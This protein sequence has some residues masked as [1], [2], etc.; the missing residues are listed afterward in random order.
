MIITQLI[1]KVIGAHV[2]ITIFFQLTISILYIIL[3]THVYLFSSISITILYH[4]YQ[5]GQQVSY[6][7]LFL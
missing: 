6:L 1:M 2:S 7:R 4:N 5:N 3:A